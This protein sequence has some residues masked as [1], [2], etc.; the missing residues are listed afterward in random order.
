MQNTSEQWESTRVKRTNDITSRARE[1][2]RVGQQNWMSGIT[3]I[4]E[5][6]N[7]TTERLMHNHPMI[8]PSAKSVSL[9]RRATV[10]GTFLLEVTLMNTSSSSNSFHLDDYEHECIEDQ[11]EVCVQIETDAI[12]WNEL[13]ICSP[14]WQS[15]DLI[16]LSKQTEASDKH[17]WVFSSLLSPRPPQAN[18]IRCLFFYIHVHSSSSSSSSRWRSNGKK[19]KIDW[20]RRPTAERSSIS[21]KSSRNG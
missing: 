9:R 15:V 4:T 14:H 10:F 13:C 16:S 21:M 12:E 20:T 7:K 6:S 3:N 18:R 8:S 17:L 1:R 5:I 11:S 19:S 2:E